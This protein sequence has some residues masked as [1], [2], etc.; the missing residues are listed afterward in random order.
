VWAGL[1]LG[2]RIHVGLSQ[3]QMRRVVGGLLVFTGLSLLWRL[4]LSLALP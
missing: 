3:E 4:L 1:T 2:T